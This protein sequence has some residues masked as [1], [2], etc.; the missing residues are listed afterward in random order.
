M[1]LFATLVV[2]FSLTS[3]GF[4]QSSNTRGEPATCSTLPCEV[5]SV[6]LTAQTAAIPPTVIFTPTT[7][8]LYRISAYLSTSA[9]KS[10]VWKYAFTWTDDEKARNSGAQPVG[11]GTF[12]A[13]SASVQSA[14]GQQI[15]YSVG[16]GAGNPPGSTFNLVITV[17]QL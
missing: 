4:A 11:P 5:A 6:T 8:G 17:E 7:A 12:S 10:S 1:K 9:T 2:L 13:F 3:I 16:A 15:T 14:A